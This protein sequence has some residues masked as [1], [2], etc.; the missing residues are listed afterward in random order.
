MDAVIIKYRETR[1][2]LARLNAAKDAKDFYLAVNAFLTAARSVLYVISFQ[3]GWAHL[4]TADKATLSLTPQQ[5]AERRRFDKWTESSASWQA[6]LTHP[7]T[8]ERHDVVHKSGQSNFIYYPQMGPGLAASPGTPF[9]AASMTRGGLP[10]TTEGSRF[11]YRRPDGSELEADQVCQ[12]Y[13]DLIW[14][15]VEDVKAHPW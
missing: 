14:K 7:L 6:V 5:E 9:R 12:E 3:Y 8:A 10:I 2:Q 11:F 4:K 1:N 15:V 13:L